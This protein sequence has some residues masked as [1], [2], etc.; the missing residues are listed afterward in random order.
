VHIKTYFVQKMTLGLLNRLDITK[1]PNYNFTTRKFDFVS[2]DPTTS[3]KLI[4]KL[5]VQ[6]LQNSI[7]SNR[8]SVWIATD[9]AST[10]VTTVFQLMCEKDDTT[11]AFTLI[12]IEKSNLYKFE[13]VCGSTGI[14]SIEC[15]YHTYFIDLTRLED[16]KIRKYGYK[17]L[18]NWSDSLIGGQLMPYSVSIN[19]ELVNF[20]FPKSVYPCYNLD[21]SILNMFPNFIKLF[22]ANNILIVFPA[23]VVMNMTQNKTALQ[24]GILVYADAECSMLLF[25]DNSFNNNDQYVA[26]IYHDQKKIC[27]Y[28]TNML[29]CGDALITYH[30]NVVFLNLMIG[31]PVKKRYFFDELYKIHEE[32]KTLDRIIRLEQV[33]LKSKN[34]AT[35]IGAPNPWCDNKNFELI[36]LYELI[37]KIQLEFANSS[38]DLNETKRE[39]TKLLSRVQVL[40]NSMSKNELQELKSNYII[41]SSKLSDLENDLSNNTDDV[42][43]VKMKISE[44]ISD[45]KVIKEDVKQMGEELVVTNSTVDDTI[46]KLG[47]NSDMIKAI[48][49]DV[50]KLQNDIKTINPSGIDLTDVKLQL[51]KVSLDV[52]NLN[53]VVDSINE[54]IED[55]EDIT[56][57]QQDVKKVKIDVQRLDDRVL[58]LEG[59]KT[60]NSLNM[61]R[62][63]SETNNSYAIT[64]LGLPFLHKEIHVVVI[65]DYELYYSRGKFDRVFR[66]TVTLDD[67]P[68][69]KQY[70]VSELSYGGLMFYTYN[71]NTDLMLINYVASVVGFFVKMPSMV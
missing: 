53:T 10:Y 36:A 26:T 45:V 62:F 29:S 16:G 20:G 40:E 24:C 14:F 58:I 56:G 55:Y 38:S 64:I 11:F 44:V 31:N 60:I 63:Y 27:N 51:G 13:I 18:T 39:L 37:K 48:S 68:A 8:C 2:G 6:K 34:L 21:T 17:E 43:L 71:F 22:D 7:T 61:K 47:T 1:K 54:K 57:M 35:I 23:D 19:G 32:V 52:S 67:V 28:Q 33:L 4:D 66:Y 30:T 42:V 5:D 41:I 3:K 9:C 46:Q 70:K 25:K 69:F 12:D 65:N 15:T 49:I 50:N 59:R